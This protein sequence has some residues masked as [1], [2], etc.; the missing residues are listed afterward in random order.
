MIRNKS[1]KGKLKV[2]NA[3]NGPFDHIEFYEDEIKLFEKL[4]LKV[5]KNLPT[6]CEHFIGKVFFDKSYVRIFVYGM[7][8]HFWKFEIYDAESR[9]KTFAST[10]SGSLNSFWHT[11][12]LIAEN[13]FVI[14]KVA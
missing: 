6:H 12:K 11:V 8:S 7:P 4:G 5:F 9:K 2:S 10:G 3:V 14:D 1:K 13:M